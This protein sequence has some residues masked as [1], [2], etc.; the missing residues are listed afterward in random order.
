[1]LAAMMI[2]AIWTKTTKTTS[3]KTTGRLRRSVPRDLC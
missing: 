3:R 2:N 1:M